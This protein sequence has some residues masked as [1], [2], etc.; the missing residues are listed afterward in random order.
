VIHV[1][2]VRDVRDEFRFECKTFRRFSCDR[3][4]G[5]R[6]E[7][8]SKLSDT[9]KA[10]DH[11]S[12]GHDHGSEGQRSGLKARDRWSEGHDHGSEGQR[13][14]GSEDSGSLI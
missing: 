4:A 3:V 8:S 9:L 14:W 10:R 2:D 12:E 7:L 11:G 13:S 1:R 5:S 6:F